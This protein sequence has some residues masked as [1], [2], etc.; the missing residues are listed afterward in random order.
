MNKIK[1]T[2][3]KRT[4]IKTGQKK[5][6]PRKESSRCDLHEGLPQDSQ[7]YPQF[8]LVYSKEVNSRHMEVEFLQRP[9]YSL[10]PS[11]D[12][13]AKNKNQMKQ[14]TSVHHTT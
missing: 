10:S 13:P 14:S 3:H 12:H 4:A 7:H 1:I 11:E 8:C 6:K 2:K 9:I 5:D